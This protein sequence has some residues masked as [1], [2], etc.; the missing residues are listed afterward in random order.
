MKSNNTIEAVAK[1]ANVSP[2]TVSRILNRTTKVS[3]AVEKRVREA[4]EKLGFDLKKKNKTK[5]IAFLLCNRSLL[6]PFHSQVLL[7]AQ[8]TCGLQEYNTLFFRCNTPS[9][10]APPS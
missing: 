5:L 2:A 7:A 6:Y 1:L 9:S 3:P 4:A 8:S 10:R